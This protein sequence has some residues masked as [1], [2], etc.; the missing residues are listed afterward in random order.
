M[1][2]KIPKNMVQTF[3]AIN[4]S[5]T[6]GREA[7]LKLLSIVQVLFFDTI[8]KS[9]CEEFTEWERS[10]GIS[11]KKKKKKAHTIEHPNITP[12]SQNVI[13]HGKWEFWCLNYI[14]NGARWEN[15]S[16]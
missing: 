12:A 6:K 13:H 1:L 9:R 10:I 2:L 7:A 16:L 4:N 3:T 8:W 14:I 15:L 5:K 11:V